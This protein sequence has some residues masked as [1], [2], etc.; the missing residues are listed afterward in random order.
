[1]QKLQ[2]MDIA[3]YV[4]YLAKCDCEQ[5]I[6]GFEARLDAIDQQPLSPSPAALDQRK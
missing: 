6:A 3:L 2:R 5:M 1:M 4:D